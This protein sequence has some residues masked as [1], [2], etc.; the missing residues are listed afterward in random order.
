MS[1][2]INSIIELT[3]K[4]STADPFE[5]DSYFSMSSDYQKYCL[6]KNPLI[7]FAIGVLGKEIGLT[8]D[9]AIHLFRG[10]GKL[11]AGSTKGICMIVA[12]V[13]NLEINYQTPLK[14]GVIHLG[15]ICLYAVDF[16]ASIA[17]FHNRYPQHLVDKTRNTFANFLKTSDKKVKIQYI[18]DPETQRALKAEQEKVKEQEVILRKKEEELNEMRTSDSF[19][20]ENLEKMLKKI[21]E[22]AK[23]E[24]TTNSFITETEIVDRNSPDIFDNKLATNPSNY[25]LAYDIFNEDDYEHSL[26]EDKILNPLSKIEH[27][28][29]DDLTSFSLFQKDHEHLLPQS[30]NLS[31]LSITTKALTVKAA[32]QKQQCLKT[33]QSSKK[34]TTFTNST[35]YRR[36]D[37][38]KKRNLAT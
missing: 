11:L 29:E 20:D 2:S 21:H 31:P 12:T 14:Q 26:S 24:I 36:L 16:F 8:H 30:K 34:S 13:I 22:D 7:R 33:K 25:V 37:Y 15:F 17:N 18:A 1:V 3:Q 19:S 6:D 32:S 5:F 28:N 23:K 9:I 35:L 27:E 10:I 38:E 4:I